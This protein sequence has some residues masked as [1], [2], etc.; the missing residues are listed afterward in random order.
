VILKLCRNIE[1]MLLEKIL[2]VSQICEWEFEGH[3]YR[4]NVAEIIFFD[5]RVQPTIGL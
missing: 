1:G 5:L 4:K 2:K 3:S